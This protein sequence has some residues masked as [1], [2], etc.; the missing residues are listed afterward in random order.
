MLVR[1]SGGSFFPW[2]P[3]CLVSLMGWNTVVLIASFCSAF[4]TS[5]RRA[6]GSW[7]HVRGQ[8]VETN[9]EALI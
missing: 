1:E 4:L 3:R 8:D 2:K 9:S 7:I 5:C 6:E